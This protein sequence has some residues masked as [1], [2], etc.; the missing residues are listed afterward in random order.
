MRKN[1][2]TLTMTIILAACLAAC[3]GGGG[4]STTKGAAKDIIPP[5]VSYTTPANNATVAANSS[6]TVT[7]SEEID[8][9]TIILA[10]TSNGIQQNFNNDAYDPA[11]R[12]VM[13]SQLGLASNSSY[14]ATITSG[15]KDLAG[16]AL[17]NGYSWTFT[18][19]ATA[20]TEAPSVT[21]WVPGPANVPV[22]SAITAV[23]SEP[24]NSSSINN[25]SFTLREESTSALVTGSIEYIGGTATFKP[26]VDLKAGTTYTASI[27]ASASDLAGNKLEAISS[28]TFTTGNERDV[29]L[30]GIIPGSVLPADGATNVS[31]TTSISI[32]FTEPIYPFLYGTIDGVPGTVTFDYENNR[33]TLTPSQNLKQGFKYH[34]KVQV[35]DLAGNLMPIPYTWSFTVRTL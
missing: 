33:V 7:F 31:E 8:P 26:S 2:F 28:L 27:A 15:V 3:G 21:R 35:K 5:E 17:A 1:I 32:A 12:T 29:T 20:D 10:I 6:V 34:T 24:M 9:A 30:P 19:S 22:N 13:F 16:N 18:T 4:G 25:D 11:S 23:F 14:T